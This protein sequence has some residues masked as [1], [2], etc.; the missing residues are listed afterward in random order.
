MSTRL[1]QS[2][3]AIAVSNMMIV[4]GTYQ[5]LLREGHVAIHLRR[6]HRRGVP[7]ADAGHQHLDH[8]VRD[9]GDAPLHW[10]LHGFVFNWVDDSDYRHVEGPDLH[11]H[12]CVRITNRLILPS[13]LPC[14][15]CKQR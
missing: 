8:S 12:C 5:D 6:G 14:R 1:L 11:R 7:T 2:H 9:D 15:L 4:L 13:L 10:R 3:I